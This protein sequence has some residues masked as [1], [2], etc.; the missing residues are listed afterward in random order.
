MKTIKLFVVGLL[1]IFAAS[2]DAQISMQ[3][4]AGTPPQW[5]P[6]GYTDVRYYYLPDVEAYYDVP[7]SMFIYHNGTTWIHRRSLPV[8]YRNYDLY[9]GY[10][11]VMTDYRGKTPYIH[12]KEYKLK[13]A[14]GY[15]GKPQKNYGER[16]HS[17]EHDNQKHSQGHN[18]NK[19]QGNSN[20][21]KSNGGHGKGKKK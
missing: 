13:Y 15:R 7:S 18:G 19:K 8:R 2:V 9:Q 20:G 16:G 11:V 21:K 4:N 3:V 10:K 1:L 17:Q 12:F 6:A 14:K 5:G